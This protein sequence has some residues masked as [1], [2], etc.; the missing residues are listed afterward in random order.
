MRWF[1]ILVYF[2]LAQGV[3][4]ATQIKYIEAKGVKI[5]VIFEKSNLP[6]F[7]LQLKFKNSGYEYDGKMAG[8]AK[9]SN[10][11]LEEGTRKLGAIGFNE[12]LE[13]KAIDI[14]SKTTFETST[15]NVKSLKEYAKDSIKYLLELLQDPN[16]TQ[17]SLDK[18]K[19]IQ[20]SVIKKSKDNFD[21]VAIL[22]LKKILFQDTPLAQSD[23]GTIESIE[24]I[25]IKDIEKFHQ[26]SF[27]LKNL[28]LVVGG[29]IKF[30]KFSQII[31]PILE[32][33]PVGE[34]RQ[35][36]IYKANEKPQ[37]KVIYKTTKQAYIYF[38]SPF[39]INSQDDIYKSKI[40]SFV[41]G[42]NGFGSR[43]MEEIRVKRGLAY[44]AYGAVQ[45]N[46]SNKFF[47]GYLQ[48]EVAKC[49]E[50]KKLVYDVINDF[51]KNGI[52][53]EELDMAKKYIT[54]SEP[55]KVETLYQRLNRAFILYYNDLPQSYFEKELE[56]IE[57]ITLNEINQY[58]KS[59]KEIL[60][61][62]FAI[63]NSKEIGKKIKK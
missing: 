4:L 37:T 54:G 56:D 32:F 57:N 25:S 29:D 20:T 43:L 53:Q 58:I 47:V 1:K 40:L 5:P 7:T 38:G 59:H 46:K 8:L 28:V 44:S 36:H 3:M 62:S 42:S 27:L 16:Y 52:T 19:A 63:V 12:K 51:I 34:D 18:V 48:T 17:K 24:K 26:R 31:M 11:V 49:Q 2:I 14:Y 61:L 45:R 22:E 23:N 13:L 55:L 33:L 50:A 39:Y 15:L 30:K 9:L 35:S 6:I 41:L 10:A 21:T 60:K